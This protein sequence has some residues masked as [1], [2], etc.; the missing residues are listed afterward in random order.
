[1]S[2]SYQA[3]G[4]IRHELPD[5]HLTIHGGGEYRKTI[6]AMVQEAK[7]QDHVDINR[8]VPTHVL[9]K[10]IK[11]A[12]LGIV[13]YRDGVFTG[14]LLPTKLME[15][16]ALGLPVIAARTPM[17]ARYFDDTMVEFFSPGDVQGLASGI[18]RLYHDRDR[19]A[20]LVGTSRPS[21]DSGRGEDKRPSTWIWWIV[22]P[23]LQAGAHVERSRRGCHAVARL[24]S[25]GR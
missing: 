13:P 6:E 3:I 20:D 22:S 18:A 1:M 14:A 8:V 5:V 17:I 10:R 4:R 2:T 21:R 15:Y 25:R 24:T 11:A 7:L 12:D 16:A 9:A 19:L 23:R